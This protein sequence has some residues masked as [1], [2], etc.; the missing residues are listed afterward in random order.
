MLDRKKMAS[1]LIEQ[2]E[3]EV[4]NGSSKGY[5][6]SL[7]VSADSVGDVSIDEKVTLSIEA[8]VVSINKSK[9]S[10]RVEFEVLKIGIGNKKASKDEEDDDQ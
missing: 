2:S 1:A 4:C 10:N 3:P 5:Y 9:G 6:P 7:S 8:K